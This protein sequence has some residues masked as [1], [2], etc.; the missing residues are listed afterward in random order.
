MAGLGGSAARMCYWARVL[1]ILRSN[2]RAL[3]RARI[4]RE[5]YPL[6]IASRKNRARLFVL[7][8]RS[9]YNA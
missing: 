6:N 7:S 9:L 1:G 8:M 3:L 5:I 2:Q 4:F